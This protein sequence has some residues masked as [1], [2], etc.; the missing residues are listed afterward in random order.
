MPEY[1]KIAAEKSARVRRTKKL[2]RELTAVTSLTAS[3][4]A[5][6]IAAAHRIP[7]AETAGGAA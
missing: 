1:H 4:R 2:I 3:Q 7:V 5:E 6:V